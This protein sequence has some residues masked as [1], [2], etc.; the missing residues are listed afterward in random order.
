[1]RTVLAVVGSI[2]LVVALVIVMAI[3][4]IGWNKSFGT[5]I[6]VSNEN[7]NTAVQRNSNQYVD[8]QQQRLLELLTD[9]GRLRSET[10]KNP[11]LADA[12]ASQQGYIVTQMHDT[13][14]RLEE[15]DVPAEVRSF[16]ATHPRGSN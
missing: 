4:T 7:R 13:A 5:W 8:S 1:M 6:G 9:Y 3:A 12:N 14:A 11:A 2:I 15:E 16:L 10:A